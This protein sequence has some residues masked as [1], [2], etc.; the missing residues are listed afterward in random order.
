MEIDEKTA[1]RL[2]ADQERFRA[3]QTERWKNLGVTVLWTGRPEFLTASRK[4]EWEDGSAVDNT[5]YADWRYEVKG[6]QV[7]VTRTEYG[8]LKLP[9]DTNRSP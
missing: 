6:D 7:V 8:F 5:V 3:A 2:A 1:A 4:W 9:D